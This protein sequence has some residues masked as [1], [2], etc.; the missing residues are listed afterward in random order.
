MRLPY[1]NLP[2]EIKAVHGEKEVH[3]IEKKGTS[4]IIVHLRTRIKEVWRRIGSIWS[5]SNTSSDAAS[6]VEN[7]PINTPR[8]L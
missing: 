4:T 7:N 6:A 2:V 3:K 8:I 5:H 1:I